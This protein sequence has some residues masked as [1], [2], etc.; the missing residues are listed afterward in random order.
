M[1][2]SADAI[3]HRGDD[4]DAGRRWAGA[5]SQPRYWAQAQAENPLARFVPFSSLVSPTM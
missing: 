3:P 4:P 2:G 5:A 1:L